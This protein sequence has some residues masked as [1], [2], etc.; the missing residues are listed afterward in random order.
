MSMFSIITLASRLS[1]INFESF[2][3]IT[4]TIPRKKKINWMDTVSLTHTHTQKKK[5]SKGRIKTSS[6]EEKKSE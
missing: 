4:L 5:K 6:H 2:K 3:K 1:K